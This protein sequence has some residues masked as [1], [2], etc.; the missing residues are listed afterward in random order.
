MADHT[1]VAGQLARAFGNERFAPPEPRDVMESVIS[2]H[3]AGWAD[4]DARV[5]HDPET[6]LPYHLVDTPLDEMVHTSSKSADANERVHPYAG[7]ISSMHSYGLYHGRYGLSDRLLIE[8]LPEELLPFVTE[9]LDGELERQERLR[10][11]LAADPATASWVT[12]DALFGNYK[13]LQFFDA[14]AIYLQCSSPGTRGTTDFLHVPQRDGDDVAIT[15][16]ELD[17]GTVSVDPW[18]FGT[19]KVTVAT[20]GRSMRPVDSET[21]L[22]EAFTAAPVTEQEVRIVGG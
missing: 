2:N 16:T 5:L 3:D 9:M 10:K 14:F 6:G 1:V 20:K 13:L 7:I 11:E 21:D 18:P 22:V 4:L 19:E 15:A 12:E 17:A 8:V